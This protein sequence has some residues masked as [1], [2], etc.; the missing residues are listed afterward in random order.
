M[1]DS[2]TL[3]QSLTEWIK[4]QKDD[5]YTITE[6]P[7]EDRTT[8]CLKTEYAAAYASVYFLQYTIAE[9]RINDAQDETV[10]Y[11]HFELKDLDHARE[12][13]GEMKEALFKLKGASEIR[14][15]LCCSCGLT[16]S[17]FAMRLNEAAQSLGLRMNFQ[18][19]PF[20]KLYE[21]AADRD[22]IMLAPQIAYQ[23]KDAQA[24]LSDKIVTTVPVQVFSNYDVLGMINFV[25]EET[26]GMQKKKLMPQQHGVAG[27]DAGSGALL[28]VSV[29]DMEGRTQ[30]AYRLYDGDKVSVE[31][32][33]VK[34]KYVFSDIMDTIGVVKQ[35]NP[36]IT[37]ICLVTPGSILDGKLT[38]EKAGIFALPVKEEIEKAAGCE[39][40]LL[41]VADAVALGYAGAERESRRTAFYFLPSGSYAGSFALVENDRPLGNA[42]YMGGEQLS[43]ITSITTF[44]QNPYTLMNTPEGNVELAARYM[45]GLI[46]YTGCD[47]IAF[48]AKMI[49][50]AEVLRKKIAGFIREEYIPEIVKVESI[51]S[52]LYEGVMIYLKGQEQE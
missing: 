11:L 41:N 33:I 12:L 38:Y 14:A 47:H 42:R 6:E 5:R 23:L 34:Q 9:Y 50:D 26:E 35:T 49:T 13:F 21:A 18:A 25:K 20:E 36:G 37:R 16:T 4:E 22:I 8:I 17:Y 43:G 31:N 15:L 39:V 40:T 24:I 27:L 28:A 44:P 32:Q 46:T 2:K 19:V 45:T 30:L 1:D 48:Y 51:R 3:A 29:V 7:A 52:Y 10:F